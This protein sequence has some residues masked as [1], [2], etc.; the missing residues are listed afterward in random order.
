MDIDAAFNT[1]SIQLEPRLQEYLRRKRFNEENDIEPP[2]PE[3]QIR[4]FDNI[5]DYYTIFHQSNPYDLNSNYNNLS[6]IDGKQKKIS[7]PYEDP[8]NDN[9]SSD[10]DG[11][12]GNY[13]EIMMDSRDLVL[14]TSRSY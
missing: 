13:G 12:D 11:N 2:I 7:K 1:N 6:R 9:S 14:G 3:K 10:S 5:D 4:N 8:N